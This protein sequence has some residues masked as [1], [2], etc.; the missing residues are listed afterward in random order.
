[1]KHKI[2]VGIDENGL[3]HYMIIDT[4]RNYYS[5][6]HESI[7]EFI[8]EE[9]GETRAKEYL[10]DGELWK[11][12]VEANK[13]TESLNDWIDT[14]LNIDGWKHVLDVET[15][16]YYD[17]ET[18]YS[19]WESFGASVNCLKENYIFEVLTKDQRKLLLESDKLHLKQLNKFNKSEKQLFNKIYDF[20]NNLNQDEQELKTS[21]IKNILQRN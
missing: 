7:G 16:I 10:E 15:F 1:M 2:L 21:I 9:I 5:I 14:V 17:E 4:E 3:T 11:M 18:Y 19:C 6:T 13:T 20:L 8:T 12:D